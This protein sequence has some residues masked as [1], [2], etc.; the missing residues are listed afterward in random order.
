MGDDPPEY[1]AEENTRIT[2]NHLGLARE[3][4]AGEWRARTVDRAFVC[5]LHARLFEAV[6]PQHAGRHRDRG[7]GSEY[8]TFGDPRRRSEHRDQVGRCLEALCQKIRRGIDDCRD[9]GD[10]PAYEESAVRLA[11]WA[12][13]E[14]IRIHPFEDGNGRTAR[15]LLGAVLVALGLRAPPTEVPRAEYLAALRCHDEA[16]DLE[17]LVDLYLVALAATLPDAPT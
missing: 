4:H 2:A 11:V 15:M 5:A 10:D 17:P 9:L 3:V 1:S 13:V 6:R 8:I 16:H 7:R 14:F 12:H